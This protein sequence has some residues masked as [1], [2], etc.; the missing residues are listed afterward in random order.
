VDITSFLIK[1][2]V[3]ALLIGPPKLEIQ[4]ASQWATPKATRQHRDTSSKLQYRSIRK[5]VLG[6]PS[7]IDFAKD[8]WAT[9][10]RSSPLA[11]TWR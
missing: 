6:T 5:R 11:D 8:G 2:C 1:R 10:E 7:A 9:Y 4:I 3:A